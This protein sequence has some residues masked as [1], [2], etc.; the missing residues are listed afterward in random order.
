MTLE[1]KLDHRKYNY[2]LMSHI[3]SNHGCSLVEN[4]KCINQLQ[5]FFQA[6]E[7][8][9]FKLMTWVQFRRQQH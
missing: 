5:W 9:Y 8:A 7:K 6:Y 4:M 1:L 3:L 2:S